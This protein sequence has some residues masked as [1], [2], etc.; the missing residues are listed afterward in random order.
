[1]SDRND[2]ARRRVGV[3]QDLRR[4]RRLT[5][6]VSASLA[7]RKTL[8]EDPLARAGLPRENAGDESEEREKDVP[9][10]RQQIGRASCRERV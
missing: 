3:L 8:G 4:F 2:L 10:E 1:M 6:E 7:G 9:P 5:E